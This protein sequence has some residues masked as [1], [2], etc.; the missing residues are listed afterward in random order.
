MRKVVY[1]LFFFMISVTIF[2]DKASAAP[3]QVAVINPVQLVD[4]YDD[5]KGLRL[6]LIYGDNFNVTGIDIG[7][8]NKVESR[9][10]GLQIGLYNNAGESSGLQIG[11]VNRARWLEGVQIG[12]IN[13]HEQGKRKFFPIVNFSF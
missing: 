1:I 3:L 9:Q 7:L 12:L 8:I 11:L 6:D 5:V 10:K 4:S 2:L 13:I